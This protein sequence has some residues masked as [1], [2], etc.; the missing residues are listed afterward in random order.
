MLRT[1]AICGAF[2]LAPLAFATPSSATPVYVHL[3]TLGE[4]PPYVAQQLTS[5]AEKDCKRQGKEALITYMSCTG[6][7]SGGNADFAYTCV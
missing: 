4:C 3:A 7:G 2:A 5:I 1:I 6:D